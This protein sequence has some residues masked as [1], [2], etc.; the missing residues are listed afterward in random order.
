LESTSVN[1]FVTGNLISRDVTTGGLST[2][3]VEE[4]ATTDDYN[5][6][7]NNVIIGMTTGS[8]NKKGTNSVNTNNYAS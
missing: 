3:G 1:N 5:I 6:I 2:Y 8:V 7:T 4:K